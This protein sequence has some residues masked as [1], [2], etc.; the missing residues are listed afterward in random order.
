MQHHVA[1]ARVA[2]DFAVEAVDGGAA[3][4]NGLHEHAVA[5]DQHA[6]DAAFGIARLG[7]LA[8]GGDGGRCRFGGAAGKE[9]AHE[10]G[11]F[12]PGE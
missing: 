3:A 7:V 8:D 2:Q 12:N 11:G 10:H 1:V 5:A 9:Q 4:F 6:S